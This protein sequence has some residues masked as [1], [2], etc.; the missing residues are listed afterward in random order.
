MATLAEAFHEPIRRA[1]ENVANEVLIEQLELL[2]ERLG[3]GLNKIVP[4]GVAL[5]LSALQFGSVQISIEKPVI[6]LEGVATGSAQL[7]LR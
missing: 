3:A 1:L 5:D 2:G 7:V 6:R 4:A